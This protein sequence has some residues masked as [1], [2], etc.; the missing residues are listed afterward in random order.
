MSAERKLSWGGE[1]KGLQSRTWVQILTLLVL[2]A[3][4][5]PPLQPHPLNKYLGV[6]D[7]GQVPQ[8]SGTQCTPSRKQK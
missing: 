6:G 1:A 5:R 7:L 8:F 4:S 3:K 2:L